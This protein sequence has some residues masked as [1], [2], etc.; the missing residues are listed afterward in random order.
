M[1]D[2]PP[3]KSPFGIRGI[4]E[5]FRSAFTPEQIEMLQ[6][7]MRGIPGGRVSD[8]TKRGEAE[9]QVRDLQPAV[10]GGEDIDKKPTSRRTKRGKVTTRG[11]H[12]VM[13]HWE[14]FDSELNE[15]A[16]LQRDTLRS[17]G[18]GAFF[19]GVSIDVLRDV[20][21]SDMA[22]TPH[23]FWFAIGI[24]A[25]ILA[26]WNFLNGRHYLN[27]GKTRLQQIKDEH[28]EE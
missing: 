1:A 5:G 17:F 7:T 16:G 27:R 4:S 2:D 18:I 21:T 23:A 11:R 13:N 20:F 15:L 24:C 9:Q 28:D 3:P 19:A 22:S 10:A 14:I 25:G 6:R 26:I 8:P 12:R